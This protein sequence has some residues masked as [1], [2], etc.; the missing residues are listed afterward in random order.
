MK[1]LV[2]YDAFMYDGRTTQWL[3]GSGGFSF[4]LP[5]RQRHDIVHY[6]SSFMKH[7]S[8]FIRINKIIYNQSVNT[9]TDHYSVYLLTCYLIILYSFFHIS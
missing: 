3:S 7:V 1:D 5:A 9:L 6:Y 2:T 4:T 8:L